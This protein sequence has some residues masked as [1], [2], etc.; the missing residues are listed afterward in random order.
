M[1]LYAKPADLVALTQ[2]GIRLAHPEVSFPEPIEPHHVAELGYVP[3]EADLLP[4]LQEGESLQDGPLRLDGEHVRQGWIVIPAPAPEWAAVIADRRWR[5][6]VAGIDVG[7]I[8]VDTDDRSKLLINGAT[9]EAMLDPEYVM[10]WKTPGGFVELTGAEVI[11]VARAVRAHVQACFNREAELL[12]ALAT[13]T[14]TPEMLD[15]GWPAS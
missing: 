4:S 2:H 13:E 5:A 11:A 7:G 1:T 9:V 12:A 10:R 14:F 8:H 3:V 6:E 15:Q